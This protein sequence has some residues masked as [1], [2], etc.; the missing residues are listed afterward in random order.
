MKIKVVVFFLFLNCFASQAQLNKDF[1]NYLVLSDFHA[2]HQTYLKSIEN[3]FGETDSL[4]YYKSKFLLLT[5]QYDLFQQEVGSCKLCLSDTSL[6]NYSA[7]HLIR[8][9]IKKTNEFWRMD[10]LNG[11]GITGNSILKK[12]YELSLNPKSD[13]SFLPEDLLF[14][15]NEFKTAYNK[16]AW[17]GGLLSTVIPASGKLYIGRTNSFLGAFLINVAHGIIAYEAINRKG[18]ENPYSIVST[19]VFGVFYLSNIF[20]T[21][22]DLKRIKNEKRKHFL[23]EVADYQSADLFLY[24]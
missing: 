3:D 15:F 24:E 16:K 4:S 23:Y 20:G 10:S 21:V 13:A 14:H 11:K 12:S 22:H 9:S 6:L 1:I 17:V 8:L 5:N 2:E 7:S 18:I 19:G